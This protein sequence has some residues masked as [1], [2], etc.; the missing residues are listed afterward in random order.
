MPLDSR[1][2]SGTM[3]NKGAGAMSS[4]V[5]VASGMQEAKM[6]QKAMGLPMQQ[7]ISEAD[8]KN[9]LNQV[10]I[11]SGKDKQRKSKNETPP[12]GRV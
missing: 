2:D 12:G 8:R 11:D 9:D 5:K 6:T 3:R 7:T 10:T 1:D 4:S